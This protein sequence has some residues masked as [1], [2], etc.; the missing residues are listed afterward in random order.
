MK[1]QN[2]K[3]PTVARILE[4]AR[5]PKRPTIRDLL[6]HIA[7]DFFEQ[8][9]DR[10]YGD[11][12]A[13]CAGI[14][15][16][17]GRPVTVI[18]H[19]KGNNTVE[20]VKV[21][22]GMPQPEGYRKALRAMR[23]AEKF[24]RPV[25]CFIDT[26][27]AHCG[28][29]AEERGQGEAIARCLY[30]SMGLKV[31]VVSVITGEGGSGG[32]LALAVANEVLMLENAVYSVISPKGFASILW[33]DAA[34]EYEAAELMRITAP[35]LLALSVI[36]RIIPEP[37]EGAHSDV[38]AAAEYIRIALLD[39]LSRFSGMDGGKAAGLRYEKYRKMGIMLE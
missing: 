29:G 18:G 31:P 28:I 36:D 37:G 19:V 38:P 6:P 14:A 5:H 1:E 20:N 22:F 39:S 3:L 8:R 27:G 35:Q 23:Q 26:P 4:L 11:D 24:G 13:I 21:N 33:K 15:R 7:E 12:P 30:E 17:H 25:V 32:A 34:R 2:G 16:I 10:C 9:G